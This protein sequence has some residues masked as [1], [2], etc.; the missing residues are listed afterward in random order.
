MLLDVCVR[1]ANAL[2]LFCVLVGDLDVELL[3][4]AH[5]QL[6]E[7]ELIRTE[8][9]DKAGVLCDFRLIDTELINDDLFDLIL[10]F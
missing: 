4:K 5:H 2:D 6:N 7:V 3:F 9:L 10:Y 8:V 1:I